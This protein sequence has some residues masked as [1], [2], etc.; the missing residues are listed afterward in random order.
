MFSF[1]W[2]PPVCCFPQCCAATTTFLGVFSS[3]ASAAAA[4]LSSSSHL[5]LV[6]EVPTRWWE[7][8]YIM[9]VDNDN[10]DYKTTKTTIRI[11]YHT[12]WVLVVGVSVHKAFAV[13]SSH[14]WLRFQPKKVEL[15][16]RYTKCGSKKMFVIRTISA[17]TK[18]V[19]LRIFKISCFTFAW[20]LVKFRFASLS[21]II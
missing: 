11:P 6:N 13:S 19:V 9:K 4:T 12:C 10:R 2:Y 14:S 18:N 15:S 8:N 16:W 7:V 20:K 1:S 17:T 3:P 21:M 5:L